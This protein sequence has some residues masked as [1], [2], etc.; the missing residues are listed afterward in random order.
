MLSGHEQCERRILQ[1]HTLDHLSRFFF[2]ELVSIDDDAAFFYLHQ[3]RLDQIIVQILQ[4][5][6]QPLLEMSI[7]MLLLSSFEYGSSV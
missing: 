4:K 5:G 2:C 1:P 6:E 3:I 7:R